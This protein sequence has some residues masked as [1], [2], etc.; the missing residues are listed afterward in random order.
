MNKNNTVSDIAY[1]A[2]ANALDKGFHSHADGTAKERNLG[3]A[4]CL[5]HSEVSE[6]MEELRI[7]DDPSHRYHR[8]EDGKPEGFIVELADVIIRIG[9]LVGGLNLVVEL[10]DAIKEKMAFN[11]TR[12]RMH[13]K[14]C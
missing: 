8:A 6:A 14:N 11:K 2:Y 10:E 12:P 1:S 9:D 4:L 13:G 5:I 3:E 7:N